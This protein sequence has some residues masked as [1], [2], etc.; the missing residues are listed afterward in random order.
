MVILLADVI[1]KCL[2][3]IQFVG[4]DVTCIGFKCG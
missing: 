1:M 3:D 4:F 2:V